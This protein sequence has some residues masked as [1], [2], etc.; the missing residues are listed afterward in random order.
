MPSFVDEIVAAAK[1]DD[2]IRELYL[3]GSYA[4][5]ESTIFSDLDIAIIHG[6]VNAVNRIALN[7]ATAHTDVDVQFTYI[8]A[9]TFDTD[10]HP[11]HVS[12]SVKREGVLLWRR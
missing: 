11:L 12:S 10:D 7:N 8:Q 4:R 1:N 2:T 9:E 3:F 5:G 6:D